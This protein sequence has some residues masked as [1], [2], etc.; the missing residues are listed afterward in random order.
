[1]RLLGE[2]ADLKRV[3]SE[4]REEIA[5][6]KGLKGRPVIKPSGM[7][8][9]TTPKSL[10]K[11]GKQR[12][13]GKLTPRVSVE[14]QII[15][16]AAVPTGSRFK[17][18]DTY[19]VQDLVLRAQV[20]RY[21]RERWLTPD[22]RVLLAPLPGSVTGHFGPELRRFVLLRHHQGQVTVE[23]LVAQLQ[24]I[25]ISISKRQVVRLLI[26]R[27][28]SFLTE[29]RACCG[30]AC[31]APPGSRL[32]TPGPVT[33]RRQW[34]LHADRQRP[35]HLVRHRFEQEPAE[36]PR[37]AAHRAHRLCHQRRRPTTCAAAPSPGRCPPPARH[38]PRGGLPMP[39]ARQAHL[40]RLGL[41]AL[42]VSPSPVLIATE[43]ALW[44]SIHDHC[45][46]ESSEQIPWNYLIYTPTPWEPERITCQTARAGFCWAHDP[47]W[48][49]RR[50]FPP[51]PD[52]AG[53][54]RVCGA[55]PGTTGQRAGSAGRGHELRSDRQGAAAGR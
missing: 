19:V 46:P 35:F 1:M 14:D 26:D 16:A 25:G 34:L 39:D 54:G 7:E 12:R 48:V 28:D 55:S 18:Y 44:G 30:P 32:T 33:A 3:V 4:Q 42:Q 8:Q 41:A 53:S 51:R 6:L 43:G 5:R 31:R 47:P 49:P 37:S 24:S 27:Q 29:S 45:C 10:G 50:G 17:G 13:R 9:A 22:G 52:R 20:I 38:S 36:L 21:R 23:R 11:H 15:Q 40:D 2:V